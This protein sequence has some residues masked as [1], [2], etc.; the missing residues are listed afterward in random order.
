[1]D[2]VNQLIL[3]TDLADPFYNGMTEIQAYN[4]LFV[5]TS[6][7]STTTTT[8]PFALTPLAVGHVLGPAKAE[9]IAKAFVAAF[10]TVGPAMIQEGPNASDQVTQ[11]FLSQLVAGNVIAQADMNALVA[12]GQQTVTQTV[13]TSPLMPTRFNGNACNV[14]RAKVNLPP[15]GVSPPFPNFVS[16]AD[17][18]AAWLAAG[19]T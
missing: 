12:L 6:T 16:Q 5:G 15:Q 19:R 9:A 18:Q 2:T 7:T 4:A 1:M 10:P 17:F 13:E 14:L 11:G 8:V 3:Q